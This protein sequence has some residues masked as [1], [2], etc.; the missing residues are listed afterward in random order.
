M[1]VCFGSAAR[2]QVLC[3]CSFAVVCSVEA[4]AVEIVLRQH[5]RTGR[6]DYAAPVLF[7]LAGDSALVATGCLCSAAETPLQVRG[8][9]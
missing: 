1:G 8:I 9:S 5:E 7:A 4:K 3:A 2:H 6:G